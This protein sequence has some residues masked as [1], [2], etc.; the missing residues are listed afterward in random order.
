MGSIVLSAAGAA[1]G[2]L[3][4]HRFGR[5]ARTDGFLAAYAVYLVLTLAAQSFRMVVLPDLTRAAGEDRLG[6]ESRAYALA[7]LAFAVP[8]SALVIAFSHPLGDTI[9][10]S[11]PHESAVIAAQAL[12]WLVPCGFVQLLA[13]IAAS[14]LAARDSYGVA[15][16]GYALGGVSGFVL[17][18]VLSTSHGLISLAWGLALNAALTLCVP[19]V[20]LVVR[21]WL[22]GGGHVPLDT[23]GRLWRLV[24]GA[25][26]PVALQ[27]FYVIALRAAAGLG[28]GQVTSLSYAYILSAVFVQATA[29]SLGLISSAPLTRRGVD[30]DA[31]ASH[32]VH[33]A[34]VSL[35]LVGAA[36]GVF[37]LVGGDIAHLV[38]GD[39]FSGAAGGEFGRLIVELAPYMVA[40]ATFSVAFPLVFVLG[41]PRVLVPLAVVAIALD[42]PLAFGLAK[43]GGLGG[44]AAN[45]AIATVAVVAV[46]LY[47]LSPQVL[48]TVT[49][50]VLRLALVVGATTAIAFWIPSL[51]LGSAAAAAVGLLV[52][53]GLLAAALRPLG[54]SE[55]W[56]YV[57]ALH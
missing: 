29:F 49:Y 12:V 10:G 41:V 8:A 30:A 45:L 40:A 47:A 53:A 18:A 20:G 37:A 39:A 42:I 35:T 51:V 28:I 13:A 26:V 16:L 54:L 57:R 31:A 9:T 25:A 56:A 17:F 14:A 34:W 44:L 55:A 2:A 15:A 7:L 38:L 5:N 48:S 32:V 52:Y 50:G 36:A 19:V 4:A 21:R 1:A 23:L 22:H 27:L 3:L 11:L 6:A 43:V 46:I 24:Q 33:S